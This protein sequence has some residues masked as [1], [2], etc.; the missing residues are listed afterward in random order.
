MN[1]EIRKQEG[2]ANSS[3]YRRYLQANTGSIMRYNSIIA[4]SRVSSSNR[5]AIEGLGQYTPYLY[6]VS[7]QRDNHFQASDLKRS[8]LTK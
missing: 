6:G 3:Q 8:F 7:P 4:A 1:D 5:P 2:I